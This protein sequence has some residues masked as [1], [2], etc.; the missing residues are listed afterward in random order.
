[1]ESGAAFCALPQAFFPIS[2]AL[3]RWMEDIQLSLLCLGKR[4]YRLS[5]T[6]SIGFFSLMKQLSVGYSAPLIL[7]CF[8]LSG[9][10]R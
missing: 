7:E 8:W 6:V 9:N 5:L 4:Q 10:L 3:F 1:M 2:K